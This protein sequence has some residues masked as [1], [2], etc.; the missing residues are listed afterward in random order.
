MKPF[1]KD[2][3]IG[4][5]IMSIIQHY[6]HE[7]Y[8]HRRT[9]VIDKDS[10]CPLLL[11]LYYLYYIKKTDARHLCSFGTNLNSGANFLSP[12]NLWHG[13]NGIIIGHDVTIGHNCTISQQVTITHGGGCVIGDNVMIGAGAKILG[14]VRI[15]NNVKIGANAVV[16][17]DVP[18]NATV[19]LQRPRIIRH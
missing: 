17:E 5:Y 15:G 6:N 19:V 10:K 16:I 13:P 11:K 2:S 12:P 8:W 3:R 4:K 7:K 9:I 14:H 1:S 18:D